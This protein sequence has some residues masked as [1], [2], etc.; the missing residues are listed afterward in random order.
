LT[1]GKQARKKITTELLSI[2]PVL[3][4]ADLERDISWYKQKLS[5]EIYFS[6]KMY[7]VLYRENICIHLQWH[8]DTPEDLLPGGSVIR[9]Y[10]KNINTL[11]NELLERGIV[12]QESLKINTHWKTN[13]FGFYDLNNNTI[14]IMEDALNNK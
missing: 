3:P 1:F 6:D 7:A 12:T 11:F 14:F 13:E 10:V 4:T 5:F 9:I 8:S 2:S